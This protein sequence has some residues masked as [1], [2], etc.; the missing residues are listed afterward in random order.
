[1]VAAV[2]VSDFELTGAEHA[3]LHEWAAGAGRVAVRAR[4]VL[5]CPDPGVVYARLADDLGV[6]VMTVINVRRRF[7]ESRLAGLEDRPRPRR[8]KA[9]RSLSEDERDQL[10]RWAAGSSCPPTRCSWRRSSTSSAS[11]TPA[12]EGD[13]AVRGREVPVPGPGPSQPVLPMVPGTAE[14]RTHDY[15]RHGVTSLF[16]AF[17]TA[18]GEG[19]CK[20][21]R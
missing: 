19:R 17:N 18:T 11:T 7:A 3:R 13:R 10:R 2:N 12:G 20:P 9:G 5:A 1:M 6:S 4:I 8:P 15:V 14:R 21:P 16:A